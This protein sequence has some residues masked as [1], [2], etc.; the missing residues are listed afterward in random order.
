MG[1][2]QYNRLAQSPA[3]STSSNLEEGTVLVCQA[4]RRGAG[5]G[6]VCGL[7]KGEVGIRIGWGQM[8]EGE[9]Y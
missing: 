8:A 7:G 5:G 3:L 2:S 4:Y 9:A 1:I 6:G